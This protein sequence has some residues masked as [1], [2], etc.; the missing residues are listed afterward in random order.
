MGS[1]YTR[2]RK[3]RKTRQFKYTRRRQGGASIYS[4]T[5]MAKIKNELTS[6][7]ETPYHMA[8][9]KLDILGC[10]GLQRADAYWK[11]LI[12]ST[13]TRESLMKYFEGNLNPLV[14]KG[15]KQLQNNERASW[16]TQK[17]YRDVFL[18]KAGVGNDPEETGIYLICIDNLESITM[19]SFVQATAYDNPYEAAK[20]GAFRYIPTVA[21]PGLNIVLSCSQSD[22]IKMLNDTTL[23]PT[24]GPS[25]GY[26]YLGFDKNIHYVN[27]IVVMPTGEPYSN[28]LYALE[29][30]QFM[31]QNTTDSYLER[32]ETTFQ[33][34]I[35]KI[36]EKGAVYFTTK[37]ILDK[38]NI[39]V[40]HIE[41][42]AYRA[43][44]KQPILPKEVGLF[45][46]EDGTIYTPEA[47]AESVATQGI[48]PLHKNTNMRSILNEYVELRS[49]PPNVQD[50]MYEKKYYAYIESKENKIISIPRILEYV[51]TVLKNDSWKKKL[52]FLRYLIEFPEGK[53]IV[54]TWVEGMKKEEYNSNLNDYS[55]SEINVNAI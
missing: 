43:T 15:L 32:V 30:I 2:K 41:T 38:F 6:N 12:N 31:N 35:Q 55:N 52:E 23:N 8:Y 29:P 49:A 45:K 13:Y 33:R 53:E 1:S 20:Q 22:V 5:H 3:G 47:F 34:A 7:I 21:K 14:R 37:N 4:K 26:Y 16:S 24:K 36:L 46:L 42:A 51:N 40:A 19:R 27:N 18:A 39:L 44:K 10:Y 11:S 9:N 17:T 25:A 50:R 28:D 48:E 54:A